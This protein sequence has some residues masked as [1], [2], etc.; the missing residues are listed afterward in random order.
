MNISERYLVL[1]VFA[2]MLAD[3]F[4]FPAAL[5]LI[6]DDGEPGYVF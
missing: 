3:R 5:L 4:S 1:A 2:R 6:P